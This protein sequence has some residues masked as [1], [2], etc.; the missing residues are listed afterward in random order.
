MLSRHKTFPEDIHNLIHHKFDLHYIEPDYISFRWDP[1]DTQS[2]KWYTST[3]CSFRNSYHCSYTVYILI[4]YWGNTLGRKLSKSC[5][6]CKHRICSLKHCSWRRN[7]PMMC[8]WQP[9]RNC[10]LNSNCSWGLNCLQCSLCRWMGLGC[11]GLWLCWKISRFCICTK[12]LHC[13]P[14]GYNI[15]MLLD[16]F[17]Y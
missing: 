15:H 13:N 5:N 8:S 7:L 14:K 2:C 6:F 17:V 3:K 4:R 16:N 12:T 11:I 9:S 1:N 10:R